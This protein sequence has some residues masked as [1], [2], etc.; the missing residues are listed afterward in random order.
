MQ[1]PLFVS[2]DEFIARLLPADDNALIATER[3]VAETQEENI[4]VS[5]NQGRF[6]HVLARLCH[7]KKILELG[8]FVGYSTIWLARA[9]QPGGRLVSLEYDPL[10]ADIARQN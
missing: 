6:L 4:S 1:H 9:L 5:P 10:H 8:T 7:P 2:T 3:S